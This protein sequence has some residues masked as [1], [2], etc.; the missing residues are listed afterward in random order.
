MGKSA[1]R[2]SKFE[3]APFAPSKCEGEIA[4]KNGL[5]VKT[6]QNDPKQEIFVQEHHS[7]DITSK[8]FHRPLPSTTGRDWWN[9]NMDGLPWW[10]ASWL[11]TEISCGSKT[12][13][14]FRCHTHPAGW[15]TFIS[16]C[17]S[18][19]AT[20]QNSSKTLICTKRCGN[21][22]KLICLIDAS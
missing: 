1:G 2:T 5:A 12:T 18:L 13:E 8:G 7:S 15:A 11:K 21:L 22:S 10:L 16:G 20:A 19:P 17:W 6:W 3:D 9:A 4:V 14:C